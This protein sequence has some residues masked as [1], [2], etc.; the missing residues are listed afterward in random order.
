MGNNKIKKLLKSFKEKKKL[1]NQD[2]K[3]TK[4]K[5]F[6]L[7]DKNKFVD[8][9]DKSR[10]DTKILQI[11]NF[12]FLVS[13]TFNVMQFIVMLTLLP[14]KEKVPYFVHFMPKD[15]QIVYVEQ[16]KQSKK[17]QRNI[18]EY[19]A[20]DYVK[21]RETIDLVTENDR[22]TYIQFISNDDMKRAF[23]EEF[24][25][26]LNNKS[27]Y[28]YSVD[29]NIIRNVRVISSSVLND[30]QYQVEFE[31]LESVRTNGKLVSTTIAVATVSFIENSN[32]FKGYDYLNNPFG[33]LVSDYSVGIKEKRENKVENPVLKLEAKP[34][35]QIKK[36]RGTW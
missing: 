16:Y 20:R 22:W 11:I 25:P 12:A 7:F 33:Y 35:K 8:I 26:D 27:I 2:L 1:K 23:A 28:K 34:T 9:N 32:Q 13:L 15:E 31:I 6:S 24:N 29:N 21:K 30:N 17:S 4:S 36:E 5:V 14:L 10:V 19:L 18:K 3:A